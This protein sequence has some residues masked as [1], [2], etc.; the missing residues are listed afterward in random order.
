MYRVINTLT[1][2]LAVVTHTER[3]ISF[4]PLCDFPKTLHLYPSEIHDLEA[5]MISEGGA[6]LCAPYESAFVAS[7]YLSGKGLPQSSL[8]LFTCGEVFEVP[9]YSGNCVFEAVYPVKRKQFF[10]KTVYI[11]GGMP[12][13]LYTECGK[14]RAR[15]VE[16]PSEVDISCEHLKR[17]CVIDGLPDTSR[18]VAY[19]E[20]DGVFR[21]ASTDKTLT[22]DSVLPLASLLAHR[23]GRGEVTV[24]CRGTE[25]RF[26]LG[27][28]HDSSVCLFGR[29]FFK[30][31]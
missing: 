18:A 14:I 23:L 25:F 22:L 2:A 21:M 4:A 7:H 10:A 11:S 15:I 28:S 8:T 12:H 13:Q 5:T 30:N 29:D 1:G 19:R 3:P 20:C 6:L 9:I 27:A 24:I 16:A 31:A 26:T 17:M